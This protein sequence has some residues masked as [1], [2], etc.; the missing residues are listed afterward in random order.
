MSIVAHVTHEAI[1]KVGGIGAVIQGLL[2]TRQY[3]RT[4]ERTFLIGPL[5]DTDVGEDERLGEGGEVLYSSSMGI[6]KAPYADALQEIEETSIAQDHS[7]YLRRTNSSICKSFV[8]QYSMS[9]SGVSTLNT[10]ISP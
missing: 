7:V 2:T 9:P 8:A 3:K 6:R 1:Q 5:H 10:R 4:I